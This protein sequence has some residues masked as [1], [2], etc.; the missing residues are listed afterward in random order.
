MERRVSDRIRRRVPCSFEYEGA[1]HEA[2][3]ADV[4][5]GGLF[6][7]TDLGIAVGSELTLRLDDPR[8]GAVE[9]RGRV[10]RRRFTPAVIARWV[11]RGV[12]IRVLAAPDAYREVLCAPE[13]AP[14]AAW[15][16]LQPPL[17]VHEAPAVPG[18]IS[19]DIAVEAGET[20]L[21]LAPGAAADPEPAPAPEPRPTREVAREP[22]PAPAAEAA[23]FG[24][25]GL[26]VDPDPAP[27][28]GPGDH[29]RPLGETWADPSRD[30]L[31]ARVRAEDAPARAPEP[32]SA[33]PPAA[34]FAL[35]C[36]DALLIHDG[37]LDD[38]QGALEALG[39][40]VV[41]QPA[42]EAT[43]FAGW[44]RP[45]R[46]I[47]ASGRSALRLSMG[48]NI[49]EQG[50]VPI[51]VVDSESQTLCGMLRRQ[52]F[53]YVVRR[54]VH[55]EALR[56]LLGRA[57][58]RGRE[59]RD[60]ARVSVGCEVALRFGLRRKPAT[61]LELSRTGCRVLI[62]EWVEPGARLSVR[63]PSPVTGNR[64]LSLAG[65]VLRSERQRRA[66]AEPGVATAL[67]FDRLDHATRMRLDALI[68]AHTLG[69]TPLERGAGGG[70]LRGAPPG[71]SRAPR[72]A[73][74]VASPEPAPAPA[75]AAA[76]V[77]RRRSPRVAHRQEVIALEPELKR[78]R[79]TLL[80]ID[81]SAG[82][83]R[84]EPHPDLAIGDRI[85]IAIYDAAGGAALVVEA[86]AV[87]DEGPRGVVL[88]FRNLAPDARQK[89]ERIVGASPQ[90]ESAG[91]EGS[92]VVVAEM[93]AQQPA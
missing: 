55:P 89:I 64:P 60:A 49:E 23:P 9:L 34:A 78:V 45:P 90:I 65:R 4:S 50:I 85:C 86:E 22:E 39:A 31:A 2:V 79:H 56:L 11:R 13:R 52:G 33:A 82:G 92:A 46:L 48:A 77:E 6:L 47:V 14:D 91:A 80:G 70:E 20:D 62:P 3:V 76:G 58:F 73:R 75:S 51:A 10:V 40:Q 67:R 88:Q 24:E 16:A 21:T 74:R 44:E 28:S 36:A 5:P 15:S 81:L 19:L 87:R 54:P 18:G 17:P 57:L 38:V 41:R 72:A 25:P 32:L 37:E 68:A 1:A 84:V 71:E 61:L 42:I 53:R 83:I 26:E 8:Y 43:G 35:C 93:L 27:A 7:Q 30:D 69:P 29:R 63:I 12:G 59:R 66:D